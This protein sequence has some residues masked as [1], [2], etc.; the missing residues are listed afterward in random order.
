MQNFDIKSSMKYAAHELCLMNVLVTSKF[1][2]FFLDLYVIRRYLKDN[3]TC[4]TM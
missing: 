2:A 4:M 1:W 3:L